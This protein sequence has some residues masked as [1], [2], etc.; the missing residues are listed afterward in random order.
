MNLN[1]KTRYFEGKPQVEHV[2]KIIGWEISRKLEILD[3]RVFYISKASEN[4]PRKAREV[5]EELRTHLGSLLPR[6]PFPHLQPV[7]SGWFG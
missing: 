6:L 7:V 4:A 2:R 1:S 3:V 5:S